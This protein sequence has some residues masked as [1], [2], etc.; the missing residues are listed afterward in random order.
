M[1]PNIK[2]FLL[3]YYKSYILHDHLNLLLFLCIRIAKILFRICIRS[4]DI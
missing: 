1:F 3:D 4:S 2:S